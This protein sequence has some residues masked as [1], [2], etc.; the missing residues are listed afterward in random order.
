M[1]KNDL[2][3]KNYERLI[4]IFNKY[5]YENKKINLILY[6]YFLL[7]SYLNNEDFYKYESRFG[8]LINEYKYINKDM[9]L[10]FLKLSLI[11]YSKFKDFSFLE[12]RHKEI[13]SNENNL[14]N[15]LSFASFYSGQGLYEKI[16]K[17]LKSKKILEYKMPYFWNSF[18]YYGI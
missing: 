7:I 8:E 11:Q 12:K 15:T 13:L 4:K 9:Y 16:L 3:I 10:Y 18:I 5:D 6:K 1:N 2:A 14:E 17:L